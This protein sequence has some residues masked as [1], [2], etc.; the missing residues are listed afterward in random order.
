MAAR[1]TGRGAALT[2]EA[3]TAAPAPGHPSNPIGKPVGGLPGILLLPDIVTALDLRA[4]CGIGAR[5]GRS[6]MPRTADRPPLPFGQRDIP[7]AL[8]GVAAGGAEVDKVTITK[9]GEI[10][11]SV[12][13]AAPKGE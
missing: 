9:A 2:A 8:R 4:K 1:R 12:K 3:R 11:I 6:K 13:S 7:R 10:V 5:T